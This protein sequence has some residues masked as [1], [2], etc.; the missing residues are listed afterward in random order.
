M[1]SYLA[2]G[3]TNSFK[4]KDIAEFRSAVEALDN[5]IELTENPDGSVSL[6]ASPEGWP[7]NC[8]DPSDSEERLDFDIMTFLPLYLQE[9][10][11]AVVK[12]AGSADGDH[13]HGFAGAVNSQGDSVSLIL[14]D[15]YE[16]AEKLGGEVS[17]D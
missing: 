6:A 9:D 14:D 2:D 7:A 5:G 12:E 13:I 11:V 8:A 17:R 1:S 15:I 4:V 16:M 10:S 3:Q